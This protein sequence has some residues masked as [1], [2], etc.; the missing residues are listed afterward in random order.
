MQIVNSQN[1]Q[2]SWQLID[3]MHIRLLRDFE[4]MMMTHRT[5]NVNVFVTR[6]CVN[7]LKRTGRWSSYFPVQSFTL[8]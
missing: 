8:D 5:R 6:D 2:E 1:C 7:A 4:G 3:V